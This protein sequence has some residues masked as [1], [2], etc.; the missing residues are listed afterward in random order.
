MSYVL[1]RLLQEDFHEW[2]NLLRTYEETNRS[3]KVPTVERTALHHFNQQVEEWYTRALYDYSRAR[4][5][6]DAITRL[7]EMTL[8]DFYQGTNEAARKAA[9][10]QY[11]RSYPAPSFYPRET[12]NLF[13]L[14]DQFL[15]YYYGLE[16]T[17]KSLQ[18]KADAKITTNSLLNLEQAITNT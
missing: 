14:E 9:G 2:E 8:K 16:A 5:N 4:R 1:E 12:V 11:A 10:I 13:D 17:V 15:F 18:A 6:K 3:L 7:I